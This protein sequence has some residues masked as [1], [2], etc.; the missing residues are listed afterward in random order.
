MQNMYK[1][2]FACY[3]LHNFL[4]LPEIVFCVKADNNKHYYKMEFRIC[5]NIITT[6]TMEVVIVGKL[7]INI[8]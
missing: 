6:V 3:A 1:Y 2:V 4:E 8:L 5:T 7:S